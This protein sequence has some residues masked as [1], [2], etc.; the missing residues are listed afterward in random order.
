M[1]MT[2]WNVRQCQD[3]HQAVVQ[4]VYSVQVHILACPLSSLQQVEVVTCDYGLLLV[5]VY[6]NC[7]V[8]HCSV[9]SSQ[10]QQDQEAA[11]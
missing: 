2:I 6:V 10:Q 8:K 9:F 4:F 3:H 5:K 1:M 7:K 11:N